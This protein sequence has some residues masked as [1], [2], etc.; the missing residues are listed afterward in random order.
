MTARIADYA[1]RHGRCSEKLQ[2]QANK[3]VNADAHGRSLPS[4]APSRVRRLR[5]RYA[6]GSRI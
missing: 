6:A 3:S 5:S 4:V 2:M 1:D